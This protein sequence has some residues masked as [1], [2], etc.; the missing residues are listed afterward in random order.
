MVN[1]GKT[2]ENH[3][4]RS[5]F[6][7]T[8][9]DFVAYENLKSPIE[10][11]DANNDRN[12]SAPLLGGQG[13]SKGGGMSGF[14]ELIDAEITKVVLKAQDRLK[15]LQLSLA[16]ETNAVV[17]PAEM[18]I[19]GSTSSNA[20]WT[21]AGDFQLDRTANQR[22]VAAT[23]L[24]YIQVNAEA[25][26]K[27][28]KK[29]DKCLALSIGTS[30][31]EG[32][33]D[34][35]RKNES[36][37]VAILNSRLG[38][39]MKELN[40]INETLQQKERLIEK[41]RDDHTTSEDKEDLIRIQRLL[42]KLSGGK[43]DAEAADAY[44]SDTGHTDGETDG[45][46]DRDKDLEDGR[47]ET[48]NNH[49]ATATRARAF[50]SAV[51]S[52]S[53]VA[54]KWSFVMVA[55][56]LW[57]GFQPVFAD[58]T[59]RE[60]KY[61]EATVVLAEA[62][63]SACV[64]L[65][66]ASY[67]QGWEGFWQVLSLDNVL[68]FA[69]TGV[70][71]AVEDTLSILVLRYVDPLTYIVFSQL[72]LPLTAAAAHFFL[73]KKPSLL[74]RQNVGVITLGLIMYGLTDTGES[75]NDRGSDGSDRAIGYVLLVVAV[76]CK[77]AASVYVDWA[78]KRR[79]FLTIPAQSANISLA[80][81]IPGIIFAFVIA[82]MEDSTSGGALFDGW[83]PLLGVFVVYILAKNWMS[84]TIIKSFSS[85]VKYVI[86]AAA[87]GV[88][89][90]FQLT[91]QFRSFDVV[92]VLCIGSIA[93]GVF[94]YSKS[95]N[96]IEHIVADTIDTFMRDSLA[97][98][99]SGEK[100]RADSKDSESEGEGEGASSNLDAQENGAMKRVSDLP[101]QPVQDY[102]VEMTSPSMTLGP[103]LRRNKSSNALHHT[104]TAA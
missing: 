17:S 31:L 55:F 33:A 23:I 102:E 60:H 66:V 47:K 15:E 62:I 92:T 93:Y 86:Y 97:G 78:M 63:L 7:F 95:K 103:N 13:G 64:G 26:R 57:V 41:Q 46:A 51:M 22:V 68:F 21:N 28:G 20:C 76:L 52:K 56:C 53:D 25:L 4:A 81:I 89:Y 29:F 79:K 84:N 90:C 72:R 104:H 58:L 11:R 50:A 67:A 49:A 87:M 82:S 18:I 43:Y 34:P 45:E 44:D 6:L 42:T 91:L 5:A 19:T 85:T 94:L 30:Q 70:L 69:P 38:P 75:S 40:S 61:N 65:M 9:A 39:M 77:V 32:N 59:L 2:V 73:E 24:S 48:G 14:N 96:T 100:T 35:N 36:R 71:R 27:L 16:S 88:T 12:S 8:K 37:I 1:W 74:E 3:A 98:H 99:P 10:E 83:T 54:L 80:T 101:I